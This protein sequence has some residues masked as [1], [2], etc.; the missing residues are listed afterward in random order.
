MAFGKP[1]TKPVKMGFQRPML[2]RK[3]TNERKRKV[4][5]AKAGVTKLPKGAVFQ[6]S[7]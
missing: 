3:K 6:G 5:M 2:V 1:A 7:E 4:A